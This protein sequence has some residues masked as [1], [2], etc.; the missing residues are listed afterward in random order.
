M[1]DYLLSNRR[2][3]RCDILH[4]ILNA[5]NE[6]E[7]FLVDAGEQSN[8]QPIV[9]RAGE[10]LNEQYVQFLVDS[11][12]RLQRAWRNRDLKAVNLIS[13]RLQGTAIHFGYAEA[14]VHAQL[15]TIALKKGSVSEVGEAVRVLCEGLRKS[16]DLRFGES[17]P[18]KKP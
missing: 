14:G 7:R 13:H 3:L 9:L 18:V 8:N 16:V 2:V 12:D 1:A 11:V 15:L 17:N 10:E 6:L 5:C 4:Q